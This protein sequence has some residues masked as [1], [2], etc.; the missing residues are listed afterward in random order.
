KDIAAWACRSGGKTLGAS[1]AAR[2]EFIW[3]EDLESRVLSG[4]ED[5]ALNMYNY[6]HAWATSVYAGQVSGDILRKRTSVNGGKLE[7]LAASQKKVRGGK[8]QR[9]FIDEVDEVDWELIEA[10]EGMGASREGRPARTVYGSTWH[11]V[12]GSMGKLV[13]GCPDNG[14]RLH[15]W[16]LWECIAQCGEDRHEYGRNCG[17]CPL[18]E[19]CLAARADF[20]TPYRVASGESRHAQPVGIAAERYGIFTVEDAIKR[21]QKLS[22]AT[23]DAEYLCKRPSPEGLVYP[24]F[25]PLRHVTK[26]KP[27]DLTIYRA[28]DWGYNMFVCLWL[29]K[30]K[31]GTIYLLDTYRA[32]TAKVSTNAEYINKHPIQNVAGTFCDPAGRQTNDQ[33]GRTNVQE[34]KRFGIN[35]TFRLDRKSTNVNNGIKLVTN[36]LDPASGPPRFYIVDT[37]ANK[38]AITAMQSYINAKLNGEW[39]DKPKDPQEYEH[40]PDALRYFFVNATQG[41]SASIKRLGAS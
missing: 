25:D 21:W 40:I 30:T 29:G 18:G 34:F 19:D 20:G 24:S 22:R 10:A 8:I 35:C 13:G 41:P 17:T 7:I 5:Q 9:M 14:V 38:I 31:E 27:N 2:L 28:I 6:W 36:H 3:T 39:I 15:K 33:T 32:E 26:S 23:V 1:I 16:N 11:R 12:A 37:P 4:S